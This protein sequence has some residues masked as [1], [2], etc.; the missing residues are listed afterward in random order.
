MEFIGLGIHSKAL[1]AH[2]E[3]HVHTY[4]HFMVVVTTHNVFITNHKHTNHDYTS[5]A[6][7]SVQCH[8]FLCVNERALSS[9]F[10]TSTNVSA[11][12]H[13]NKASEINSLSV[14]SSQKLSLVGSETNSL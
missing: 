2:S 12:Y 11:F 5:Q 1:H 8:F 14:S 4:I 3:R 7:T 9:M 10:V 6:C 13:Q